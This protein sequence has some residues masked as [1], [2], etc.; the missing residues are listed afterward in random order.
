M[1]SMEREGPV[2]GLWDRF[3]LHRSGRKGGVVV[4]F[5]SQRHRK[6]AY[7]VVYEHQGSI[8]LIWNLEQVADQA[9]QLDDEGEKS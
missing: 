2:F 7:I 1:R 3:R 4:K 9:I 6:T 8:S 5:W